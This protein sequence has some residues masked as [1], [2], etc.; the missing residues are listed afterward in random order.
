[1]TL[2]LIKMFKMQTK[3]NEKRQLL[4]QIMMT[5]VFVAFG[6]AKE[7]IF[8]KSSVRFILKILPLL[9]LYFKAHGHFMAG[10][11]SVSMGGTGRAGVEG[12]ESLFLNPAALAFLDR[13]YMGVGY[14]SGFLLKNIHRET[15]GA[16]LTDSTPELIFSG[17]LAYRRHRILQGEKQRF[18]EDEFKLGLAYGFS[19]RLSLGLAVTHLKAKNEM[20]MKE[21]RQIN[22]DMGLL[23]AL[24]PH[25]NLSL[26]GENL[27]NPDS[28]IPLPLTRE[29]FASLGTQ[30]AYDL[31]LILRY[32]V[33]HPLRT[34]NSQLFSHRLGLGVKLRSYFH[35]NFGVSLDEHSNQTW[36]TTGFAWRGPRLKLAYAFQNEERQ[37]LGQR[38]LVD[39][40]F[41]L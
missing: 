11:T 18:S 5:P 28:G 26:V 22:G 8:K 27:L 31:F 17:S 9:F 33:L 7:M 10:S 38:H 19:K 21:I 4:I 6:L 2:K 14:Q 20:D 23:F 32:E 16:I 29:S 12:N 36:M 24:T 30:Y 15:Y 37:H 25:W 13:F 34:E 39:L 40:W 35:L 41:D 1:M 3:L